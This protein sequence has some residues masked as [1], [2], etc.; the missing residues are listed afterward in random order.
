[1]LICYEDVLPGFTRKLVRAAS[2]NLLVNITNDAW[3]GKTTEPEIHLALAV[4]RTVE[5]R[6][7]LVRATN[8]G[9]SAIIDPVGRVVARTALQTRET[10]RGTV[11]W[12]NGTTLYAVV[13]DWPGWLALA[14]VAYAF[15]R[16]WR[17]GHLRFRRAREE[18]GVKVKKRK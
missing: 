15:Y 16:M 9:I 13:G 3:F 14:A 10:L 7:W 18:R 5:H 11:R 17:H 1:V 6:R 12:Q 2:P 8:S 4:F